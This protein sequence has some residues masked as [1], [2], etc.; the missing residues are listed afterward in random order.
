MAQ[1]EQKGQREQK[2]MAQAK[3]KAE[4]DTKTKIGSMATG[5]TASKS[6]EPTKR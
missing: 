1:K 3:P 2:K 4:K 6:S 5:R